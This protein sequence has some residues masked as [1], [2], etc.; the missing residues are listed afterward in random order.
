MLPTDHQTDIPDPVVQQLHLT[1]QHDVYNQSTA[2]VRCFFLSNRRM[3]RT[4]HDLHG[5]LR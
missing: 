3:H 5:H 1:N 4:R 2:P